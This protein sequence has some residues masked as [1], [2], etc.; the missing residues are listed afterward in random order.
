LP[1][2]PKIILAARSR[3]GIMCIQILKLTAISTWHS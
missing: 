2:G 3:V 1:W